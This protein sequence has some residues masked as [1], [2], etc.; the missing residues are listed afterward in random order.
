MKRWVKSYSRLSGRLSGMKKFAASSLLEADEHFV[1]A[2]ISKTYVASMSE[3]R[4]QSSEKDFCTSIIQ[5][6]A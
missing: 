1:R 3:E 2:K 4:I 6:F 5:L